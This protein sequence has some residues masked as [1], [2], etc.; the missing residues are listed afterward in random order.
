ML[1]NKALKEIRVLQ[2]IIY[3]LLFKLS[4]QRV[5]KKLMQHVKLKRDMSFDLRIQRVVMNAL[6]KTV[7]DF[8]IKNFENK[9]VLMLEISYIN[10]INDKSTC[11]SR[12]ARH[13]S[14]QEYETS[15]SFT[16]Q[17]D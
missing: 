7:E 16:I 12:Q 9:N 1:L 14:N 13:Y 10:N 5:V 11:Y 8:L 2:K 4:F 17:H 6:Q 15:E 3:L